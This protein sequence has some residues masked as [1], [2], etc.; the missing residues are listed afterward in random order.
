MIVGGEPLALLV[1]S[2][3]PTSVLNTL[4]NLS[5]RYRKTSLNT[6]MML[7]TSDIVGVALA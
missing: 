2:D 3:H 5:Y 6:I 7:L 1:Q 4:S